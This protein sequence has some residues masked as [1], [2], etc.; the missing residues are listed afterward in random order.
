MKADI[1]EMGVG[2]EA[3]LD[4]TSGV[5][6][7]DLVGSPEIRAEEVDMVD[8]GWDT[9]LGSWCFWVEA[10]G[11]AAIARGPASCWAEAG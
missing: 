10:S 6:G 2:M 1:P 11:A 3:C 4:G 8:L 9:Q 7:L 5:L